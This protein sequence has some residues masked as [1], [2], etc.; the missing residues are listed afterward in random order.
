MYLKSIKRINTEEDLHHV[1]A[2]SQFVYG[3][4]EENLYSWGFGMNYVLLNGN[5]EN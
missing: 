3:W 4:N 1:I 2:G 5:E